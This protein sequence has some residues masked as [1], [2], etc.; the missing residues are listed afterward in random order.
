MRVVEHEEHN[1]AA[2]DAATPD[3]LGRDRSHLF[4]RSPN[5]RTTGDAL[6]STNHDRRGCAESTELRP[7]R[8]GERRAARIGP[9]R[10]VSWGGSGPA[11]GDLL[12]VDEGLLEL[13]SNH[14][15]HVRD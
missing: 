6:L 13:L 2:D 4:A 5:S 12:E 14:R 3:S 1:E 8:S 10:C 9:A 11:L 15:V 7:L